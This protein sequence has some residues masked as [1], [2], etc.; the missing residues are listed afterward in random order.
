MFRMLSCELL[1]A[2]SENGYHY[3]RISYENGYQL[4]LQTA[5]RG[6]W[7]ECNAYDEFEYWLRRAIDRGGFEYNDSQRENN[8][9]GRSERFRQIYDFENDGKAHVALYRHGHAGR[10][11]D[12]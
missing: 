6:G 3:T 9:F 8:G 12:S 4:M 1:D 2:F 10:K 5:A 11:I 7:H